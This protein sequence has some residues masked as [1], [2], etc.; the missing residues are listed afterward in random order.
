M[1]VAK[2]ETDGVRAQKKRA[3]QRLLT[4]TGM[5]LFLEQGYAETTLDQIAAEAGVSR[6]TIFS[7]FASKE[8]ILVASS[9][10]GWD[11][12]LGDIAKTSPQSQPLASVCE[13]LLTRLA[14]RT[15]EDLLALRKLMML[16]AT[17]RSRGQTG[18]LE[19]ESAIAQVMRRVWAEPEREWEIRLA[20]M[21]AVGAFRLAVETWRDSPEDLSLQTLTEQSFAQLS[22]LLPSTP[23][24]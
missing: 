22:Q 21:A 16:S 5:R 9:D 2:T 15:N 7:Y 12:I 6:R 20:A 1:S 4:Q 24:K 19:R 23:E 10:D 3:T 18:F 13:C 17:L 14:M 11:D 8:D